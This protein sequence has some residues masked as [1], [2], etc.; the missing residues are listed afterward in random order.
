MIELSWCSI[1]HILFPL[2]L[3]VSE[4]IISSGG[5]KNQF[6]RREKRGRKGTT[7]SCYIKSMCVN[8]SVTL[9]VLYSEIRG[10]WTDVQK[11]WQVELE[12]GSFLICIVRNWIKPIQK[13]STN[14]II[15][16]LLENNSKSLVFHAI[17]RIRK[18]IQQWPFL[19][20]FKSKLCINEPIS[21]FF[22]RLWTLGVGFL[23][24]S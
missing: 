9:T 20:L 12:I 8:Q 14:R 18:Q 4:T 5:L 13:I 6:A 3:Q 1:N 22:Q 19:T 2:T 11:W 7:P 10:E 23:Y 17:F 15:I 24:R 16:T 21:S